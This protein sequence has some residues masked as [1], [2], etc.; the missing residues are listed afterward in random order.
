MTS[1]SVFEKYS[2]MDPVFLEEVQSLYEKYIVIE[3]DPNIDPLERAVL[4]LEWPMAVYK[5]YSEYIT[6]DVLE[7]ALEEISTKLKVRE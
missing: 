5:L 7:S 4:M 6:K 3:R 1:Y 2:D